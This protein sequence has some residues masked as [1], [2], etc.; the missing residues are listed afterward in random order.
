MLA[1][2]REFE[3]GATRRERSLLD[4]SGFDVRPVG[5]RGHA[6]QLWGPLPPC[7]AASL[8]GGL[9]AA[10]VRIARG[11][12]R[13]VAER[14]WLAE[15]EIEDLDDSRDPVLIDYLEL[16]RRPPREPSGPAPRITRCHTSLTG[17]HGG[18]LYLEVRGSDR[19]GFLGG[20]LGRLAALELVPE[21]LVVDTRGEPVLDRFFLVDASH[22]GLP[23]VERRQA[24]AGLLA[25]LSRPR[26]SAIA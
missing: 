15:L 25:E 7:W 14:G 10:G 2:I 19:L 18:S 4:E 9:A 3:G 13:R 6:L 1:R 17:K 21:E 12:A 11:Y 22:G 16:A 23:D 5:D 24:L 20:L 26:T 8:A